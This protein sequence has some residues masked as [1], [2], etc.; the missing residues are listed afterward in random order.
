MARP[1]KWQDLPKWQTEGEELVRVNQAVGKVPD[2]AVSFYAALHLASAVEGLV[3]KDGVIILE[4]TEEQLQ[5]ALTSAQ[6]Q[7]DKNY[8]DLVM[9][10]VNRLFAE[11]LTSWRK[12]QLKKFA[13]DE[14]LDVPE[15]LD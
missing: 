11:G 13:E 8:D 15:Y 4:K 14:G 6:R 7:W 9:A 12:S 1:E 10:D 3:V 2:V 5:D